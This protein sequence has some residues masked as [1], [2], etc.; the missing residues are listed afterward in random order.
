[1]PARPSPFLGTCDVIDWNHPDIVQLATE[2][3]RE[4]ILSTAEQC[5][6]FVRDEIR[7]SGDAEC[8]PVTCSASEVLSHGTGF[9]YAKSHLLCALLRANRISAGLC[10]QRLSLDGEG[11]PYCLHGLNAVQLP[12]TGWY[13]V[14]PR[15]NRPGIEAQFTPPVER[16]AFPAD[17]PGEYELPHVYAAPLPCVT[18]ALRA[19]RDWSALSSA[20]PDL[21]DDSQQPVHGQSPHSVPLTLDN[22][23]RRSTT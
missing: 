3:A 21:D 6:L 16:L 13:R 9:C 15:G 1:M 10:Y 7:H 5:F 19:H 14:D 22:P 23:S 11:P 2:L 12:E 20:L 8:N 4:D 17:R 18:R